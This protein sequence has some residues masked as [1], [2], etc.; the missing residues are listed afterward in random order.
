[1]SPCI[2]LIYGLA[3][4]NSRGFINDEYL[5]TTR[6]NQNFMPKEMKNP[7]HSGNA[8][9]Q[10]VQNVLSLRLLSRNVKIK[11]YRITVLLLVLY[12]WE[13][14]SLTLMAGHT[15]NMLEH[16]VLRKIFLPSGRR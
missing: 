12:G 5:G 9:Y 13:T 4:V 2:Y 6:T 11:I 14:W 16:R 1:M 8:F 10:Q 7:L 15:L 3:F